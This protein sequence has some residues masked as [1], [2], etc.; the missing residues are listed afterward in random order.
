MAERRTVTRGRTLKSG[1][2]VFNDGRSAI[3]CAVRNLS[4]GGACLEVASMIGIPDT[5]TLTIDGDGVPRACTRK[6][7]A[8]LRI[9]VAFAAVDRH[10]D[11]AAEPA[12]ESRSSTMFFSKAATADGNARDDGV[13]AELLQLRAALDEVSFGVVLLDHEL[14]AQFINKAF[15]K[16]WNLPDEKADSKPAYV[17]LLYHGRDTR[18]YE[19]PTSDVNAYVAE[20][21][22]FVK[23]GNPNAVDLRL[24]NGE[25]LRFQ[26]A[27]LP[28]GGRMLSYT[29]VTDIVRKSD[30]LE[31]LRAALDRVMDGVVVLDADL[32]VRHMNKVVRDLWQIDDATARRL[33]Y[34][35][36]MRAAL[37]HGLVPAKAER[38]EMRIARHLSAIRA[39]D[40]QPSDLQ[41]AG[42]TMRM[43][44][45]PLANGGHILT[46]DDI[47]DLVQRADQLHSMANT[48]ELTSL[49]NRR[50][51]LTLAKSEWDRFQRYHRPLSMLMIDIDH[52]K[53]INDS[54]G[55]DVGDAA[56]AHV[57]A[58]C[59]DSRRS[60]D[61][62]ARIGGE[63]FAILMP[64]TTLDQAFTVGER[65]C[66]GIA[67][68][69]CKS[70]G[71]E[72]TVTVSIG[73]AQAAVGMAGVHS[74]MKRADDALYRAKSL[75]RN[76]IEVAAPPQETERLAAE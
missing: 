66:A 8:G 9:G 73:V 14:R 1:R 2:I 3:D 11:D 43:R 37:Q 21:V 10:A 31:S 12:N 54:H 20:R 62:V 27:V 29:T 63:E 61:A 65:L 48:D 44:C 56:L 69:P 35:D 60:S 68:T 52:F 15:R 47:S 70:G 38:D 72:F 26:C 67:A 30:E 40:V 23:A 46:Y 33:N 36:L 7:T 58:L 25:V 57:A 59:R 71:H 5:F 6:W 49:P 13:R 51:F 53:R 28:A 50:S 17:A 24:S 32:N 42:R 64:E 22:A 19:I 55:H 74:L 76:R 75:G 34:A 45:A 4:G 18:A 39:D 41:I 16:M